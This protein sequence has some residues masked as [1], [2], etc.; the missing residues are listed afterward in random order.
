MIEFYGSPMSSSGRTHW[1]LE[2]CDVEYEYH[3]VD[4]RDGST[5]TPEFRAIDPFGTVPYIVDG[6]MRLAESI[7]INLYL[8]ERYKPALMGADIR[9]RA[10][11]WQWSLWGITSVQPNA[12]RVMMHRALL[13]ED[14][15]DPKIAEEA[16]ARVE[17]LLAILEGQL[18][19]EFLVGDRFT[20]ADVN[21][22]STVNLAARVGLGGD[23]PRVQAWLAGLRERPAYQRAAKG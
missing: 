11:I 12:L 14:Q 9:E 6:E 8:A 15:R 18:Q 22:G 23:K 21:C 5:R 19:G 16:T 3:R 10:L 7:A 17:S 1:M 20:A 4:T 13:P 2:E